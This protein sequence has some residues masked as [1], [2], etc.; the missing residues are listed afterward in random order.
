MLV[1]GISLIVGPLLL[2]NNWDL[3]INILNTSVCSMNP[4]SVSRYFKDEI[5]RKLGCNHACR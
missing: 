3:N 1:N 2:R 5:H 4:F